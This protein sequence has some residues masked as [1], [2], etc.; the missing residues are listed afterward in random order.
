MLAQ[1]PEGSP[2]TRSWM[3]QWLQDWLNGDDFPKALQGAETGLTG[4]S[5]AVPGATTALSGLRVETGL[6]TEKQGDGIKSLELFS[7]AAG[8]AAGVLRLIRPA[9]TLDSS[10]AP[11]GYAAGT[12]HWPGGWG[13]VGEEG[14]E[15]VHLPQGAGVYPNGS[16]G[17]TYQQYTI[18]ITLPDGKPETVKRGV[19]DAL[20]ERGV[21]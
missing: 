7:Q 17:D 3:P 11:D 21:R 5:T 6:V 16:M 13:L 9:S 1:L 15:L 2:V 14:P 20:R 19:L 8:V 18:T 12:P 4:L 10:G